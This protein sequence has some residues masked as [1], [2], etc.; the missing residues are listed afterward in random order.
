MRNEGYGTWSVCLSVCLLFYDYM[1]H[2]RKRGGLSAISTAS[3][4]QGHENER[5][6]FT[7]TTVF[8]RYGVKTSIRFSLFSTP[9][10]NDITK[11]I[12]N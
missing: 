11:A 12:Y 6:D 10:T 4:L 2:Y 3:A 8:E 7:E 9:W 5:G 1:S